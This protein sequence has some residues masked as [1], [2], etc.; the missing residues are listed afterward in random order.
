MQNLTDCVKITA[1]CH[2]APTVE[3]NDMQHQGKKKDSFTVGLSPDLTNIHV[4]IKDVAECGRPS[5]QKDIH[6][7]VQ[8]YLNKATNRVRIEEPPCPM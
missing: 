5:V 4:K 3:E 2:P 6:A 7:A 1:G 8:R